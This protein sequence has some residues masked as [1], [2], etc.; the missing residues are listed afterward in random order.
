MNQC[1]K[2]G[3]EV[4]PQNSVVEFEIKLTSLLRCT[5]VFN[6]GSLMT[7]QDRH[8]YPEGDCEGSP[9]R[10]QLINKDVDFEAA[11]YLLLNSVQD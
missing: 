10:V 9:S 7:R 2:C 3:L 11:Y 6:I 1:D 4:S 8:L 5:D